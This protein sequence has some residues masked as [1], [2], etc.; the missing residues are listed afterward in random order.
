MPRWVGRLRRVGRGGTVGG[1]RCRRRPARPGG[2]RRSR[3]HGRRG[4]QRDAATTP[5]QSSPPRWRHTTSVSLLAVPGS[6]LTMR[7]Q[8]VLRGVEER[9]RAPYGI[10][11]SIACDGWHHPL[12]CDTVQHAADPL[13]VG[14]PN[15]TRGP[16]RPRPPTASRIVT[17]SSC[18]RYLSANSVAHHLFAMRR[19]ADTCMKAYPAPAT[20]SHTSSCCH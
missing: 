15:T 12:C 6:V 20:P 16:R 11:H 19:L 18:S 13:G 8:S 17:T 10:S 5:P 7:W 1:G 14:L 4:R 2:R 9:T 3:G